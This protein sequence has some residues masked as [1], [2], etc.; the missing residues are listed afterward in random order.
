MKAIGGFFET[1]KD[2]TGMENCHPGAVKLSSGRAAFRAILEAVRPRHVWVPCFSCDALLEP[3]RH[4]KIPF[5]FWALNSCLEPA[6]DFVLEQDEYI[7]AVNYFGINANQIVSLVRRWEGRV[8]IDNTQAFFEGPVQGCFSFNSARKFYGVP[9]GSFLYAPGELDLKLED[10][11]DVTLDHLNQRAA[12]DMENGYRAFQAAEA[13]VTT[14]VRGMSRYSKET[15]KRLPHRRICEQR[16]R[17]FEQYATALA[18]WNTLSTALPPNAVPFCYPFLPERKNDRRRLYEQQI[19]VPTFWPEV[20]ARAGA[21]HDFEQRLAQGL[22]PLPVDHRYGQDEIATVIQAV[23]ELL[24]AP[25][26][27][28]C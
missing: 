12:G 20:I 7:V 28:R 9:D 25:S 16:R 10:N 8:I 5:S 27:M 3:L 21:G 2:L 26:T 24:E 22:L 1:E 18:G 23:R 17:N 4:L 14:E 11:T 19:F 15:L 6:E 13:K